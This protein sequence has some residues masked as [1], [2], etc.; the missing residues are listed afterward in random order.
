MQHVLWTHPNGGAFRIREME[1]DVERLSP[2]L[3]RFRYVVTGDLESL[4]LPPPA[5]P[6]RASNLWKTT[7]LEAFLKPVGGQSYREFNFSPSGQWAAYEFDSYR[8]G[9]TEVWL[10]ASPDIALRRGDDSLEVTVALSLDLPDEP[11]RLA[12]A[13]VIEERDFSL[14]YWAVNH[15]PGGRPPDFHH[16]ACFALELPPAPAS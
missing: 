2:T 8:E 1:A 15:V 13:A 12:L 16:D 7:C 4:V 5:P 3:L 10:P 11:Y 14:S 6:L 9:M